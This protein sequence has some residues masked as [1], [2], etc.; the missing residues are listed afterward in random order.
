[1]GTQQQRDLARA[2]TR[3]GLT[4][5]Q[6]ADACGVS[7]SSVRR[8]RDTDRRA[9]GP[10]DPLL[11]GNCPICR[12]DEFAGAPY[13]YLLGIYLGDGH[14]VLHS[15]DVYRLEIACSD[16]WPGLQNEA[17]QAISA[18]MPHL[19]VGRRRST[20]CT[21]IGA[22]SKHWPCLFPQHGPGMKHTRKIE[23]AGWQRGIVDEFTEE[24]VRGLI[25]SDGCRALNRVNRP[26]AEG[27]RW[28]EYPRYFFTNAS[29][30]IRELFTGALD[31]L[32]VEWRQSSPRNISVAKRGAVERLDGFVGPKF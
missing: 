11:P 23:L 28:Y 26:T 14:I 4:L 19:K 30:D 9:L 25:H 8:W 22:Y 27:D 32:G 29:D 1:M 10:P 17:M 18:V 15:R 12:G 31:R 21:Y 3:Q 13:S 20:G 24:F 7:V 2:L 16:T 5:A 6:I